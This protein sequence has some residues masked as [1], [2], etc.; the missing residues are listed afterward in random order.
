MVLSQHGRL[1]N[2]RRLGRRPLP[3]TAASCDRR[4]QRPP[5][6]CIN[7]GRRHRRRPLPATT[8][9]LAAPHFMTQHATAAASAAVRVLQR[10]S[11][12]PPPVSSL[13]PR[14]WANGAQIDHQTSLP[15]AIWEVKFCFW[16]RVSRRPPS[17]WF[18]LRPA[19]TET[20]PRS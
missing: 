6:F 16:P 18:W 14:R 12:L 17:D 1:C 5:A 10:P 13:S 9:L 19:E 11:P 8:A 4:L 3:A 2:G 7:N 15:G 20:R